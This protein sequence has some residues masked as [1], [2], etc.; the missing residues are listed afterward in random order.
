MQFELVR[1]PV[2]EKIRSLFWHSQVCCKLYQQKEQGNEMNSEPHASSFLLSTISRRQMTDGSP[3][4]SF[5][6]T[7]SS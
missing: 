5:S 7:S 3:R 4:Q 6:R 1:R 2:V